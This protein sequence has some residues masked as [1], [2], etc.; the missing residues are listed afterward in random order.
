ASRPAARRSRGGWRAGSRACAHRPRATRPTTSAPVTGWLSTP[1]LTTD[2]AT[3]PS[4]RATETTAR[5]WSP[6]T[7]AANCS[8]PVMPPLSAPRQLP[9][10]NPVRPGGLGTEPIDLVLVV[11]LEV[12]LEPEP[13][14]AALP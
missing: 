3:V 7:S 13:V 9:V 5:P 10:G 1:A 2:E 6:P 11:G 14:R 12:S 8:M 4:G